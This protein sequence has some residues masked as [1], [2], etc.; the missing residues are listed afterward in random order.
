MTV[1][2]M[3]CVVPTSQDSLQNVW[4]WRLAIGIAGDI[5]DD[6]QAM[7]RDGRLYGTPVEIPAPI[8]PEL[9]AQFDDPQD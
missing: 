7:A 4:E 8:L 6:V 2:K 9:V 5:D 1:Q 3:S